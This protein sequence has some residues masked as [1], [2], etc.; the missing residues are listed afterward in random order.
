MIVEMRAH[1]F[2]VFPDGVE[3]GFHRVVIAALAGGFEFRRRLGK[4]LR[5]DIGGGA[6]DGVRRLGGEIERVLA[7]LSGE[8]VEEGGR[9]APEGVEDIARAV[10]ARS[11]D[12][13]VDLF[14][15]KM[16]DLGFLRLAQ[17]ALPTL[18]AAAGPVAAAL[19]VFWTLQPGNSC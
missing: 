19:A 12:E 9:R 2:E 5:A 17:L 3:R 14:D 11:R 4:T 15:L 8:G 10:D 18:N 7:H 6:F 16:S 1:R 13:A